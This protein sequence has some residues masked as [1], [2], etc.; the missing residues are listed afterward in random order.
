MPGVRTFIEERATI[1][2]G[3][4]PKRY[5]CVWQTNG[6]FGTNVGRHHLGEAEDVVLGTFDNKRAARRAVA[7]ARPASVVHVHRLTVTTRQASP[8]EVNR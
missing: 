3:E 1:R 7:N 5:G 2:F 4:T 6:V 8:H